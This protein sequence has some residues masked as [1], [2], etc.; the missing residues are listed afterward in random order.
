MSSDS[1]DGVDPVQSLD[2]AY[3]LGQL[4]E[5]RDGDLKGVHRSIISR[6]PAVCLRD[7]DALLGKGVGDVSEKAWA[8]RGE[9]PQRYR[10]LEVAVHVPLHLDPPLRIRGQRLFAAHLV[11]GDAA[12]AGDETGDRISRHRVAAPTES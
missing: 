8:V 11:R 9:H 10:A 3:Q 6:C 7:V 2:G 1:F 5:V 12:A 4:L